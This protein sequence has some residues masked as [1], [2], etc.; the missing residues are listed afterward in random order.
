MST[1]KSPG[2]KR[3]PLTEEEKNKREAE[4]IAAFHKLATPRVRRA[5]K[6]IELVGNLSG[7]G[8][9]STTDQV[10]KIRT[11][12]TDAV[13]ATMARFEKTKKTEDDILI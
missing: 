6:A 11:V 10:E 3:A 12:L 1:K 7:S 2:K 5:K 13:T 8:Y 9:A 4:K